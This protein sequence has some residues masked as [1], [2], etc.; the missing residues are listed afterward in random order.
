MYLIADIVYLIIYYLVG[1]RRAVVR[2]NLAASFP[3]TGAAARR[4]TGR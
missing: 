1:Y 4:A 3:E 2:R